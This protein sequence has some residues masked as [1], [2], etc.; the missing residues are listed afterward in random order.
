VDAYTAETRDWLDERYRRTTADGVYL[1]HQPIY[2]FRGGHCEPWLLERYVRTL[3]SMRALSRLEFR[4]LLDVGA[5]E[6]Y[7]AALAA[8]LFGCQAVAS[9]LS[10][11]ACRRAREIYG[12]RAEPG[13][14]QELPFGDGEF[15]VVFCSE[16]L[17]HV[18]DFRQGV[19]ELLRVARGAVVITVPHEPEETIQAGEAAGVPHRH[20]QSL[21]SSSLDW[22]GPELGAEVEV[23]RLVHPLSVGLSGL[24]EGAKRAIDP[25]RGGLVR[26]A[27]HAHNLLVPVTSRIAGARAEAGLAVMDRLLC[28]STGS[29]RA[30]QFVVVKDPSA[31]RSRPRRRVR[32]REVIGFAVPLLRLEP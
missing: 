14:V 9:D 27:L 8:R 19:T 16:T 10:A 28:R 17:E 7:K 20:V 2:G 3:E 31:R 15:D 23:Q 4:T 25:A 13:D 11:E 24:A 32:A 21:D 6:G 30:I 29:Y 22:V 12:L 5:S 1:A 18:K 26:A